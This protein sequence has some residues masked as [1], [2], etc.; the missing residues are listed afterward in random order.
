MVF[1]LVGVRV[2]WPCCL[3]GACLLVDMKTL[4]DGIALSNNNGFDGSPLQ[5]M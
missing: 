1:D 3:C 5:E 4:K 2:V